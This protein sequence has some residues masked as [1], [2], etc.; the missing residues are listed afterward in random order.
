MISYNFYIFKFI[1]YIYYTFMGMHE[2]GLKY[3]INLYIFFYKILFLKCFYIY[4]KAL[5]YI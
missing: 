1:F 4:M 5:R 2:F 3:S